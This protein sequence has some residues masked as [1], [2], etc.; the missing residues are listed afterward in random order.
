MKK[1]KM[2]YGGPATRIDGLGK[3]S[4]GIRDIPDDI[5]Q[6]LARDPYWAIASGEEP[7]PGVEPE[8]EKPKAEN[9]TDTSGQ[10]EKKNKDGGKK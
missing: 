10:K 5:A 2:F 1:V 7:G 9:P 4:T 6:N 3:V 8:P